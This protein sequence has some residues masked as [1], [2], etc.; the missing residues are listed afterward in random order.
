MTKSIETVGRPKT[1]AQPHAGGDNGTYADG[2][3]LAL[4]QFEVVD[5]KADAVLLPTILSH[6]LST[7]RLN[8]AA[9]LLRARI[10]SPERCL[11]QSRLVSTA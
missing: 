11:C 9:A 1:Q 10:I 4:V 3:D 5:A 6:L 8:G 2:A 7:A